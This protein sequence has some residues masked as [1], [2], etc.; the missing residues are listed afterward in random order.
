ENLI[1]TLDYYQINVDDRFNR[2]TRFDVGEEERQVLIDS[3]VPGANAIDLVS[4]FNNDMD[5]ET[6]GIDLVA[7]WSFDWRHGLT[8]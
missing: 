3:G 1:L 7:T 2:S 6:E 8:T 4:F 5:T